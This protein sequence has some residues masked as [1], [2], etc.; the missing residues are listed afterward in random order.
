MATYSF[1]MEFRGGTYINQITAE[2]VNKAVELWA[3]TLDIKGI[4][5]LSKKSKEYII[6]NL[7]FVFEL[8]GNI[9]TVQNIWITQFGF[10]TGLATIHIF[11]TDT[12]PEP[13][14]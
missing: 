9:D 7:D 2:N 13:E 6:D 1:F 8:M 10:K 14:N 3:N 5:Y 12:T 11:K 4:Q